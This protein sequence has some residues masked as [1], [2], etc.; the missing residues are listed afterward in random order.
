MRKENYQINRKQSGAVLLVG[1]IMVLLISIISIS[2]IKG[3]NLQEAIAGN[4][5]ERNLAFQSAESGLRA[6][7]TVVADYSARPIITSNNGLYNDTFLTPATSV[8]TFSNDDWKN[9]SKVSVTTLNLAYVAR[10]PSYVIE[11]TNPD[12][13]DCAKSEGSGIDSQAMQ[14]TGDCV[15]YRITARGFG[16]VVDS[17]KTLQTVYNRRFQ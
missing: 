14:T 11:Q 2:A 5:R 15:P 12:V 8:L 9:T 10:Q 6:G 4:M 16:G 17:I 7:E 3:S 1:L 13:G